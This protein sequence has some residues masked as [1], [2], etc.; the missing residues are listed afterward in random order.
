MPHI[1]QIADDRR[2]PSWLYWRGSSGRVTPSAAG[3]PLLPD[4]DHE[5]GRPWPPESSRPIPA[6][7]GL[8][9]TAEGGTEEDTTP[10]KISKKLAAGAALPAIA[11]GTVAGLSLANSPAAA[12]S[13]SKPAATA[14]HHVTRTVHQPTPT[15]H[16]AAPKMAR[17]SANGARHTEAA[18]ARHLVANRSASHAHAVTREQRP[19]GTEP[20]MS[21][22]EASFEK[23]VS[24]RESGNTPTDPDGLFGILPS[25]WHEL[26]YSGSAGQ[27]SVALQ[28]I[29]FNRLYHQYGVQP[30]APSDGC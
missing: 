24:W 13:H 6:G 26:G 14:V 1:R 2:S 30:W 15:A 7:R 28:K 20:A 19:R 22:A 4:D 5:P 9:R 10:V 23:C 21:A 18:Q 27:A 29:A 8:P 25:T 12:A 11:V 3:L 16:H 17:D